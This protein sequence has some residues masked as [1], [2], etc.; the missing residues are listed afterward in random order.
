[1]TKKNVTVTHLSHLISH[2]PGACHWAAAQRD[3]R[4]PSAKQRFVDGIIILAYVYYTIEQVSHDDGTSSTE[5]IFPQHVRRFFFC[6]TTHFIRALRHPGSFRRGTPP[7]GS[8]EVFPSGAAWGEPRAFPLRKHGDVGLT[9][10]EDRFGD[11]CWGG[12]LGV[13]GVFVVL[14]GGNVWLVGD[15]WVF[16]GFRPVSMVAFGGCMVLCYI[17]C[18]LGWGRLAFQFHVAT[19]CQIFQE[20]FDRCSSWDH[21][22][23]VL[24]SLAFVC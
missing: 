24:L 5:C 15:K 16:G 22:H 21:D 10:S 18:F 2:G 11:V 9:V 8:L 20:C 13:G 14:F 17:I 6:Y 23:L 12:D 19:S 7:D 3:L 4:P 1:M